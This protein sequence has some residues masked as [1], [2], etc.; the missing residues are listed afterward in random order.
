MKRVFLIVLDSCGIGYEPD[1]DKFGDVGANTLRTCAA[2]PEFD[3]RNLISYGLG[4]LDGVDCLPKSAQPSTLEDSD[5]QDE[6]IN[7]LLER[8]MQPE[9]E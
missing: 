7:Q 1:A 8:A 5:K 6:P 4:N 9:E 2:S 3:M